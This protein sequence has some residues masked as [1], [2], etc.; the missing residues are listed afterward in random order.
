MNNKPV[1]VSA[2][3][4]V[5]QTAGPHEM[6]P[7]PPSPTREVDL[8]YLLKVAQRQKWWILACVTV[9]LVLSGYFTW[10]ETRIYE[11]QA[12]IGIELK[13]S[14][15]PDVMEDVSDAG[16]VATE[17]VVLSSRPLAEQVVQQLGLQL[18]VTSP[19]GAVRS[20]VLGNVKVNGRP[21]SRDFLLKHQEDGRFVLYDADTQ[22][23][24]GTI[25]DNQP[26]R[27]DS[28]SFVLLPTAEAYSEIGVSILSFD[29]AVSR[30][31]A[32]L[33]PSRLSRD[34]SI[35]VIDYQDSDPELAWRVPNAVVDAYIAYRNQNHQSE[36]S[37]TVKFLRGQLD[38][39]TAQLGIS[40]ES[41][42]RYRQQHLV[43]D[44]N[45]EASSQVSQLAQLQ[46]Q[47]RDVETE[48]QVVGR[49][50]TQADE[51]AAKARPGD[52][53]PYRDLLAYPT[54]MRSGAA[55]DLLGSLSRK[56]EERSELLTRRTPNDPDV[57]AMTE[58]IQALQGQIRGVVSSYLDGLNRQLSEL[59]LSQQRF[60][61][62]LSQ[63]PQTELGLARLERQPK[64]LQD[65][66]TLLQTRLK[67]A[68][69]AQ[70]SEDPSVRRVDPAIKPWF[71]SRPKPAQNLFGGASLGLVL[72]VAVALLREARDKAIRSRADVVQA[73][74]LP[75]L[76]LIPQIPRQ[77]NRGAVL[78]HWK[79]VSAGRPANG[80][81]SPPPRPP[82]RRG[83]TFL[84]DGA[85][86]AGSPEPTPAAPSPAQ[87][88]ESTSGRVF[89]V[90]DA[91][92]P[93]L[94][95]YS[96]LQTNLE[97]ATAASDQGLQVLLLTSALAG[98]GKTT[99]AG[100]LAL[101]LAERGR[102]V[103]LLDLDLRQ[104]KVHAFF[105]A[106]R[107]PGLA[108]LLRGETSFAEVRRTVDLGPGRRLEYVAGGTPP[109]APL[110]VLESAQLKELLT[111]L[112]GHYDIVLVDSPP[113]NFVTDALVLSAYAD[114]VILVARSGRTESADLA[115]A[116]EQLV[117]ADA[118]VLGVA[119]NDIDFR[120]DAAHDQAYRY[121]VD[122]PY[123]NPSV[124]G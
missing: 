64:V 91:N 14:T 47:Q 118:P 121:F 2:P 31:V 71:P 62:Q 5:R 40:E 111:E 107:K 75:V 9:G 84:T 46:A 33:D 124:E 123:A 95:A 26:V 77:G 102:S 108:E 76:G 80:S 113:V 114:G 6:R 115:F 49:L 37:Q 85:P 92:R 19:R 103:I 1:R 116:I 17:T 72:G 65:I 89:S 57:Q 11:A 88:A 42:R 23:R 56:E 87:T 93:A 39:V 73:T 106:S 109:S 90:P 100:N 10:R 16:E 68:E 112:R 119:L 12:S 86:E 74:G 63:I 13:R 32:N 25:V 78:G 34:A 29:D 120:G 24:L 60:S 82:E 45:T 101:A 69:I 38:S 81:A 67:E 122:S 44:P 66:Y 97:F 35:I 36:A 18:V 21:D 43:I 54:L 53:S 110:A 117:R 61:Q 70:A 7:A 55:N 51:R 104:G 27:I 96:A 4:I 15:L 22:K 83:Y 58:R 98:E 99:C 79:R 105:E 30:L 8:P 3:S 59:Q 41:L 94:E 50:L 52:P 48:R 28:V 20:N